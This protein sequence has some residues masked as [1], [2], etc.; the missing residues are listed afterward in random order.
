ML[1]LLSTCLSSNASADDSVPTN[2]PP[3]DGYFHYVEPQAHEGHVLR[4]VV[5]EVSVLGVGYVQYIGNKAANAADWDVGSDWAGFRQK[6]VFSATS[7]DDNQFDTNWLTHPLAGYCYYTAARSNQIRLVPS[8]AITFSSSLFWELIGEMREHV[9]I[10]DVIVTPTAGLALGEPLLQLGNLMHR[11]R[12][13]VVRSVL[14]WVFAPFKSAHDRWDHVTPARGVSFDE[15]GLPSEIWHRFAFGVEG[16]VTR[17]RGSQQ[18]GAETRAHLESRVVMLPDYRRAGHHEMIFDSGEVTSLRLQG[19]YAHTTQEWVDLGLMAHVMPAG[20]YYQDVRGDEDELHGNSLLTGVDI[21][22]E[23]SRH[24][25]DRD[26]R[27]GEDRIAMVTMGITNEIASYRGTFVTR[28]RFD[29]LGSFGG[30]DAYALPTYRASV[31]TSNDGLTS[32][33]AKQSY[34]HS[35]GATLRPSLEIAYGRVAAYDGEPRSSRPL[36]DAGVDLRFDAFR[37][38]N[39]LDVEGRVADIR[40]TDARVNARLYSSVALV[41][42]LRAVVSVEQNRRLGHV[43]NVHAARSEVGFHAGFVA[44]F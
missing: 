9:A 16:G 8:Y 29:V 10:N 30:V 13:G 14:G 26:R 23:Y 18:L 19:A 3:V 38:I 17:Q 25:F 41:R 28:G 44:V 36:L 42:P 7:F 39:A 4:T 37:A 24:D 40:V 32:V 33:V 15:L 22:A 2:V 11:G 5:E 34:Y 21:G 27:R 1:A 31:T 43:G 35:I 20:I 12:P 6:L